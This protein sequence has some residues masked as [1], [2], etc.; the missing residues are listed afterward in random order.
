MRLAPAVCIRAHYRPATSNAGDR[1]FVPSR[2]ASARL[3][4]VETALVGAW[5]ACLALFWVAAVNHR[6]V[7]AAALE[8]DSAL[9]AKTALAEGAIGAVV[10]L[11][12]LRRGEHGLRLLLPFAALALMLIC[13]TWLAPDAERLARVIEE[14][15]AR[16]AERAATLREAKLLL[17]VV[18]AARGGVL[19]LLLALELVRRSPKR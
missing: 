14:D 13:A 15:A 11:L 1:S 10:V 12:Q 2:R 9:R 8:L 19:L 7:P 17:A 3:K 6:M 18:D 16:R 5:L 4:P